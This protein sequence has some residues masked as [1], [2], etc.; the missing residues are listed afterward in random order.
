MT[1][2]AT[3]KRAVRDRMDRTGE[4]YT[5]A[6]AHLLAAHE[7]SPP[8]GLLPGWSR[9]GG[10][11][12]DLAATANALAH[13]GVVGPLGEP[14]DEIDVLGL[15]G[16]IGFMYA[17]FVYEDHGPTLTLTTRTD[18]MPDV[19]LA[20]VLARAGATT[21]VED[22]RSSRKA[23]RLLDD[24]LDARHLVLL[25]LDESRLPDSGRVGQAGVG[26]PRVV[27]VVGRDG[28]GRYLLDDTS[29]E[30]I[31]VDGD[32]LADARESLPSSTNH[33]VV[34]TGVEETHDRS[35][36]ALAALRRT[37]T[38]YDEPPARPF[39]KNTGTRGLRT[40]AA[41]LTGGDARSWSR[42]F[43]DAARRRD[44][45]ARTAAW[46]DEDL[47]APGASR[48]LW[49]TWVERVADTVSRGDLGS[50]VAAARDSEH[51]W[52]HL[53][54]TAREAAAATDDDA[55]TVFTDL[56]SQVDAIAAAERSLLDELASLT[57]V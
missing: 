42:L 38:G 24:A 55:G 12:P 4:R 56:A 18:S 50:V 40:W 36:A 52:L 1:E 9:S 23:A 48:G 22:T 35:A 11:Q 7:P 28:H 47:T 16:G 29:P 15:S 54:G 10:L 49:A 51:R 8:D 41:A 14:I 26:M 19:T 17:V 39:A 44:A 21:T 43:P 25:T 30:P 34:V 57:A 46:I 27:G 31:A 5:T 20:Q 3:F 53:A 6:R 2:N 13:V 33:M 32:V 45:L 37:V